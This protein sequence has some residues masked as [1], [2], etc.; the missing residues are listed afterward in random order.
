MKTILITGATGSVGRATCEAL[1]RKGPVNLVLIG[2]DTD[3]LQAIA[4]SFANTN[5]RFEIFTADLSDL[6]SVRNLI[7]DVKRT[8][9]QLHAL[10]NI[11]AV[12]KAN[13]QLTAQH[14]EL[15]FATNHLGPYYLTTRL[16]HLLRR[17]PGS[18]VITVAAPSTSRVDFENLN[19]EKRF[20]SLQA[21]GTS[22]M[23]NLLMAFG[24]SASFKNNDHASIALH[25][26][27]VR[28]DL[29]REGPLLLRKLMRTFSSAPEQT[30]NAIAELVF[31]PDT[32]DQNGKFYNKSLKEL[33]AAPHA[34][35]RVI[36]HRLWKASEQ[37][38]SAIQLTEY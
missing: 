32:R 31:S 25:P 4:D 6:L 16:L 35:D 28:S 20:S 27:L 3:K 23:M 22:K 26:G 7:S 5:N 29:L 30:G 18:K 12:F 17:T 10:V 2:R 1:A 14:H 33:Q 24:L 38:A 9:P 8:C 36:Q 19:S 37:L 21:F 11:A 15:M 13:R 34:Y